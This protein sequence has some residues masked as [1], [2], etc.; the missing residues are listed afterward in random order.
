M[1]KKRKC[2]LSFLALLLAVTLTALFLVSCRGVEALPQGGDSSSLLS[3]SKQETSAET[4][5][6]PSSSAVS[7]A[8]SSEQPSSMEPL[9]SEASRPVS[10]ILSSIEQT[11]ESSKPPVSSAAS[12]QPSSSAAASSEVSNIEF[13]VGGLNTPSGKGEELRAVWISYLEF[14]SFAG[15]DAASFTS[16]VVQMYDKAVSLGLNAVIV[17]VRPYGDSI[18]PS[19]LFPWS[20]TV[21]GRMGQSLSYDPL[22]ILI[23]EAH[24]RDLS[25]HAWVNPY[26]TMTDEEMAEISDF[27]AIKKWYNS[28]NRKQY[29]VLSQG[30]WWLQP[31]QSEVQKLIV[32]GV[33][34]IVRNYDVDG[35]HFDD[36]FYNEEPSVYG[37][38]PPEAKANTTALVRSCYKAI[39]SIRSSVQFGIS[40]QGAFREANALPNSDINKMSTD[41]ALWCSA[42]GYIDYVMPQIY[43]EYTHDTQPFTMTLQKWERFVTEPGVKLYVGLAPYKLSGDI[44]RQQTVDIGQSQKAEGYCLFRYD[45]IG[46]LD[47]S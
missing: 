41:L 26:R 10:E 47:L 25:F 7:F 22:A 1:K 15:S 17:Q 11:N 37:D 43:W 12:S 40:P 3:A 45:F 36:Y 14:Q 39:K 46:S 8:P 30:R 38:T 35:I 24:A 19:E 28:A 34:E 13:N 23:Q 6:P 5:D 18:Y 31:G 32:S 21:S 20:K 4:S 9:P 16:R 42:S 2:L 29:M 33:E 27:Y 44:I